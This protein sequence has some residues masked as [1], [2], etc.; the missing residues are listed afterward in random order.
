RATRLLPFLSAGDKTYAATLRLGITT[1]SDDTTGRV[2]ATCDQA[3]DEAAIRTAATAFQG[4]IEQRAPAVSAIKQGGEALYKKARRGEVVTPPVR[5]VRIVSL[6]IERVDLAARTVDFVVSCSAG[7]YVRSLA[8]DWGEALGVG[9]ALSALRRNAIGPHDVAGAIPTGDLAERPEGSIPEWNARLA[10][11]GLTP[12]QAL[13]G[14]PGLALD[15]AEARAVGTGRAPARRRALEAGIPADCAAFR[16]LDGEGALL[17]VGALTP[18][19]TPG[20]ASDAGPP[21]A[22][23]APSADDPFELRLVWAAREALAP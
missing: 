1:D 22:P 5:R 9:G 17:G 7:T 13:S 2:T 21:V 19:A 16:L 20:A 15:G 8:R 3:L 14:L 23:A 18:P 12:E 10:A 11:A 4:T 6:A